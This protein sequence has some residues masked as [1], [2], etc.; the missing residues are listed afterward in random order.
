MKDATNAKVKFREAFRPF[1]PAILKERAHEFFEMPE[2][3]DAPYMLLVPKVREDKRKLIPAVTHEDGTG[4]V[5]TVTE[6]H[7]GRYYRLIKRFGEL[8]GVPVLIN[9]SFNVRGE[10]IVCTPQ[11]AYNTFINTGIDA[12]VMGNFVVRDKPQ[13]VDFDAGMK[14]SVKLEESSLAA[15]L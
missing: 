7:N 2:G 5:Q 15:R 10:P 9:T 3:M 4:R 1:A 6:E 14:R 11:D 13:A 12:L 8:T